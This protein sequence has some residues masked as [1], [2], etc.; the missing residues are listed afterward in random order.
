MTRDA[1][2][3]TR[4]REVAELERLRDHFRWH[5]DYQSAIAWRLMRLAN[6]D[7][8]LERANSDT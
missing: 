8:N 5:P 1:L 4:E 6:V 2:L 3:K 7:L